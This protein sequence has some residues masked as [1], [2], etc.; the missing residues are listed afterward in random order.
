[1]RVL[2]VTNDWPTPYFPG[3][4]THNHQLLAGLEREG[5]EAS[6]LFLDRQSFG[7]RIYFQIAQQVQIHAK[8]PDAVCDFYTPCGQ[9]TVV[10]L[11]TSNAVSSNKSFF[12]YNLS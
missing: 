6:V 4:G 1:M 9:S 10:Q 3:K 2:A 12:L 11:H 7:K 5:V 8:D